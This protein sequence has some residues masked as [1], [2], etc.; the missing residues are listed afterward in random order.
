MILEIQKTEL[1][2]LLEKQINNIFFLRD[3]ERSILSGALD[4]ALERCEYCFSYSRSKY[5]QKQGQV[6]FNPFHSGQYSIFLYFISNTIFQLDPKNSTL[7]DRVYYLN[8]CLNG[9]DLFYEVNMP[10]AFSLGH[11]VGTVI[12]RA[13]YG[14]YFGI[15][16][17]CT[18]GNS[19]G[20]YPV[21]GENVK[22]MAGSMVLGD[23]T[24][25][26]DV[27]FSANSYAKDVDIP[28]CS[29]V[30]GSSPNIVIKRKDKAYFNGSSGLDHNRAATPLQGKPS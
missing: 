3:E 12:G 29:I 16:Q 22:L 1:Q 11:P 15:S 5:Y 4:I 10:K 26:D 30:F 2:A 8:K 28:S 27:I 9:L 23:C 17:N 6:Y 19:N 25:G 14:E 20:K 21:F 24:V 18:V 13:T 7:A